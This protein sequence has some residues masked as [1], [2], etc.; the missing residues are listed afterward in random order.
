MII[1]SFS[2]S[3]SKFYLFFRNKE[4]P[5][6]FF[7]GRN[8]NSKGKHRRDLP[9]IAGG[10]LV[11]SPLITHCKHL[12]PAGVSDTFLIVFQVVIK[13]CVPGRDLGLDSPI[14]PARWAKNGREKTRNKG[15]TRGYP[16]R[17]DG[18]TF[19]FLPRR[20]I[21]RQ[22]SFCH[23]R[24]HAQIR[25]RFRDQHRRVCRLS[26]CKNRR[27]TKR[28]NGQLLASISSCGLRHDP[29]VPVSTSTTGMVWFVAFGHD[30][31]QKEG[32]EKM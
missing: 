19:S 18:E 7:K 6:F 28:A 24:P 30:G 26:M 16:W 1:T 10:Q 14:T 17:G 4:K 22:T 9:P 12:I 8:C 31:E 25:H 15:A 20:I 5:F 27:Q 21:I 11:G 2:F 29:L 32:A 23:G 13:T 3:P